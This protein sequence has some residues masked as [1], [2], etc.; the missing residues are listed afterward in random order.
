MVASECAADSFDAAIGSL[1]SVLDQNCDDLREDQLVPWV[2][3]HV[4][5]PQEGEMPHHSTK[6]LYL[7]MNHVL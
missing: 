5:K 2:E 4:A 7:L 1:L 6:S 3:E